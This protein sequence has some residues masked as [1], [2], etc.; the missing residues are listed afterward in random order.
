[1][2]R[3]KRTLARSAWGGVGGISTASWDDVLRIVRAGGPSF[4]TAETQD[5]GCKS[6]GLSPACRMQAA[7]EGAG[8]DA[9]SRRQSAYGTLGS[10][11]DS[12]GRRPTPRLTSDPGPFTK[13]R[14]WCKSLC[15]SHRGPLCKKDDVQKK[16]RQGSLLLRFPE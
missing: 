8:L 3:R 11:G 5:L 10:V 9:A 16:F 2:V 15:R 7:G 12:L 14:G 6:A 1:M 13:I 4:H